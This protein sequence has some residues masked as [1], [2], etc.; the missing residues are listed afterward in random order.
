MILPIRKTF[1]TLGTTPLLSCNY[2]PINHTPFLFSHLSTVAQTTLTR[3]H[4]ELAKHHLDSHKPEIIALR[5]LDFLSS[6]KDFIRRKAH[7]FRNLDYYTIHTPRLAAQIAA[8]QPLLFNGLCINVNL[9]NP[10][11]TGSSPYPHIGLYLALENIHKIATALKEI[12]EP[13]VTFLLGYEGNLYQRLYFLSNQVIK[14]SFSIAQDF[15]AIAFNLISKNSYTVSPVIITDV[16]DMII[17]SFGNMSRFE[18]AIE[19]IKP[20]TPLMHD[21]TVW[22]EKTI[23]DSHFASSKKKASF[24]TEVASWRAAVNELKYS[25]GK[26]GRG[27]VNFSPHVTPFTATGRRTNMLALQMIP[28]NDPLPH[29]RSIVYTP[30][31][32]RWR[33]TSFQEITTS[34]VSYLPQYSKRYNHPLFYQATN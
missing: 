4:P 9:P 8:G 3:H 32:D 22:Y 19:K 12:Y 23:P 5:I 27:F 26:D 25:G 13:G 11:L 21:W 2:Q 1:T 34:E 7:N 10:H 18:T 24:I 31:D 30:E 14:Q 16:N 28:Q 17:Q 20:H 6:K 29:Q 15:N 33:L